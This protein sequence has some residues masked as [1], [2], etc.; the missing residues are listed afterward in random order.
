MLV[1]GITSVKTAKP[2]YAQNR[3]TAAYIVPMEQ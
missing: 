2:Y 3:V 1:N